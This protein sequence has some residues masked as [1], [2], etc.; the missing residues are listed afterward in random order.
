MT[1][2]PRAISLVGGVCLL[3][4]AC[5]VHGFE[6]IVIAPQVE[7]PT[8]E[9]R[10]IEVASSVERELAQ[11][12]ALI[13]AEAW[14]EAIDAVLPLADQDT[15]ELVGVAADHFVPLP[16]ACQLRICRWPDVAL[17]TYRD[18]VEGVAAALFAEASE[19]R[20]EQL[21]QRVVDRYF[22]SRWGDDALLRLGDAALERGQYDTARGYWQQLAP[23]ARSP[24]GRPWGFALAAVPQSDEAAWQQVADYV[25]NA[26]AQ[27]SATATAALAYPDSDIPLASILAR[28]ATA[29]I[30][31]RSFDRAEVELHLLERTFPDAQGIVGGR[32]TVLWRAV[33]DTLSS[34][35]NW[36]P[37]RRTDDWPTFG[38]SN[39][40]GKAAPPVGNIDHV[41]WTRPLSPTPVAAEQPAI[42][43]WA[44]GRQ[45]LTRP[46][47]P[48]VVMPTVADRS[49]VF[50]DANKLIGLDLKT[51]KPRVGDEGELY[52]EWSL[53][54]DAGDEVLR[55]FAKAQ[56]GIQVEIRG[57]RPAL[58]VQQL[59]GPIVIR[60]GV[61]PQ[62]WQ[63][64]QAEATGSSQ[65]ARQSV[66]LDGGH[67][68]ATLGARQDDNA[69]RQPQ[70]H[71][72]LVLDLEAEGK[73]LL[74]I[75]PESDA[76]YTGPPLVSGDRIYLPMRTTDTNNRL[77]IGCYAKSTGR[78]LWQTAVCSFV[79][80]T[81]RGDLLAIGDGMLF[82]NTCA[83]V[84]AA[85]RTSDGQ[86]RWARTY[87]RAV[88]DFPNDLAEVTQR[89]DGPCLVASGAVV[90]APPDAPA[91]MALDPA[92]GQTLWTN[93]AAFDVTELV[94]THSGR[95]IATGKRMWMIDL[96]TGQ[97]GMV[98]PDTPAAGIEGSGRGAI[99]GDELFWPTRDSIRTIDLT[100]GE[101]SRPPIALKE[102]GGERANLI[103]V[104]GALLVTTPTKISL[105]GP[106]SDA[107]EQPAPV[108][109]A[110]REIPSN[111]ENKLAKAPGED[112]SKGLRTFAAN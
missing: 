110:S 49:V 54:S 41:V 78:K 10:L 79:S 66:A 93:Q 91:L 11:I 109:N 53:W 33:A 8:A 96:A 25:Q 105:L 45:R 15:N 52:R 23:A 24:D 112:A 31:E 63:G 102:L 94:G 65:F 48:A 38:G 44:G 89:S 76:R 57:A 81:T 7:L 107:E 90:C 27:S 36:P 20:S 100:T 104:S 37:R 67:V 4:W 92:T 55:P 103:P 2:V 95:L 26:S 12:D 80:G 5:A 18:R 108:K 51:G 83:G 13:E 69:N 98:W 106:H 111:P 6:E 60:R 87:E 16:T 62:G 34:A 42:Q 46:V 22:A 73:L 58:R 61:A 85:M 97:T 47:E 21:L 32:Q 1:G 71:R 99:A 70:P 56:G 72:L 88:S 74:E 29:S 30:R 68:Y 3:S 77:L 43:F 86:L 84:V 50:R 39:R 40:R 17:A 9:A 75:E 14:D 64:E 35:K 28:L 101:Q 59:Q 19:S 82:V